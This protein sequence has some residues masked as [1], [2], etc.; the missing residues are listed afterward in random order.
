MA[1][2][3]LNNYPGGLSAW[4]RTQRAR[5]EARGKHQLI[6][7]ARIGHSRLMQKSG[8]KLELAEAYANTPGRP[9]EQVQLPGPIVYLYKRSGESNATVLA[10][11]IRSLID[12][13][14]RVSG[15]YAENHWL[16]IDGVAVTAQ[17][18]I[19]AI[20]A[21]LRNVTPKS[22]IMV[23]NP[24]IYA[25]RLEVGVTKSGRPFVVQVEPRIYGRTVRA[26]RSRHGSDFKFEEGSIALPAVATGA[27]GRAGVSSHYQR[28]GR[29]VRRRLHG[30]AQIQSPA[31][32]IKI[33]QAE[34]VKPKN[35]TLLFR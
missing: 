27:S 20:N 26:L 6:A 2:V 34:I 3:V 25:R 1:E 18:D 22:V 5:A 16:F 23:A 31:I 19:G 9:I 13:S 33:D 35:T 11:V 17:P 28:R 12:A 15:A 24:V 7:M 4:S 14:P 21:A 8:G 32:I 29:R 10:D 30:G